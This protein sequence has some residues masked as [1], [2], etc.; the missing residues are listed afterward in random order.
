MENYINR[1]INIAN[2]HG[3][4]FPVKRHHFGLTKHRGRVSEGGTVR[5]DLGLI[6]MTTRGSTADRADRQTWSLLGLSMMSES[7]EDLWYIGHDLL[8]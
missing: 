3:V 4:G 8:S 6:Q 7:E 2:L 5:Q 1:N